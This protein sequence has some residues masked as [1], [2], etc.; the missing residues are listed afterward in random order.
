AA[1]SGKLSIVPR[2]VISLKRSTRLSASARLASGPTC[3]S[4]VRRP[5]V[6]AAW[7]EAAM[8]SGR[9]DATTGGGALAA[10]T[11][12]GNAASPATAMRLLAGNSEVSTTSLL[13][14]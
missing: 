7:A 13:V 12:G 5:E 11:T 1:D 4:N 10:T 9:S 14:P 8:G 3:S 6:A 2:S